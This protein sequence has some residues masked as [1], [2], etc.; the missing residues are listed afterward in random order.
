MEI[1]TEGGGGRHFDEETLLER[2]KGRP[3]L[4]LASPDSNYGDGGGLKKVG[5]AFVTNSGEEGLKDVDSWLSEAASGVEADF[6]GEFVQRAAERGDGVGEAGEA[7]V[8]ADFANGA[9]DADGAEL[10][11]DVGVAEDDGFEGGG[12]VFGL[13]Q[14][15][16]VEDGGD[17]LLREAGLAQDDRRLRAGIGHMIPGDEGIQFLGAIA[18]KNAE[19]MEPGGGF[20]DVAIVVEIGADGGCKR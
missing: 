7:G 11:E 18:D 19:V 17:F 15:D 2:R 20:D 12:R 1:G 8:A 3:F 13:V 10:F 9:E 4:I 6:A 16:R 5:A 14:T